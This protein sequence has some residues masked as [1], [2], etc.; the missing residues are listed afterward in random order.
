[1]MTAMLLWIIFAFM[2]AAGLAAVLWP[3]LRSRGGHS[4][5]VAVG[6][7]AQDVAVYRDQLQELERDLARGVVSEADAEAGRREISRRLLAADNR[8]SEAA[9]SSSGSGTG[10]RNATAIATAVLIPVLGLS[11]YLSTGSPTLED[12]PLAKRLA[13]PVSAQSMP[14]LLARVEAHLRTNPN[15]LRGWSVIAPVYMRLQRYGDAADAFRRVLNLGPPDAAVYASYGEALM[16]SQ[17]GLVT[18]DAREAFTEANRLS[19]EQPKPRY[20]LALAAFQ[21]GRKAEAIAAWKALLAEGPADAPWRGTV[22]SQIARA[23]GRSP[24]VTA[25]ALSQD[26]VSAAREMAPDER[27][28]MIEGMVDRLAQRLS[29]EGG[30]LDEWLRLAR[31]QAVLGRKKDAGSTLATARA[32]FADTPTALAQIEELGRTMQLDGSQ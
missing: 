30:G 29:T 2:T 8:T 17:E 6:E 4:V 5:A 15:D 26:T 19:P 11:V 1:M 10:L 9:E 16:L 12:Q 21:E 23:E 25:P 13:A 20:F 18:V 28:K 24:S 27:Q 7:A 14:E 3:L 22:E 31:A 32:K